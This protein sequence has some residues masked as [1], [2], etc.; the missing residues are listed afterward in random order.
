MERSEKRIGVGRN[1]LNVVKIECRARTRRE[2]KRESGVE[3]EGCDCR[4]KFC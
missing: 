3:R 2:E 1:G 4:L